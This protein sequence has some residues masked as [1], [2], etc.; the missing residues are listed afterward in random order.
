MT[1][2]AFEQVFGDIRLSA[3]VRT[4]LRDAR[5][6]NIMYFKNTN[7]FSVDI[8]AA[9]IV[10]EECIEHFKHDLRES[11][12]FVT[13][14]ILNIKY[15]MGERTPQQRIDMYWDNLLKSIKKQSFYA[16]LALK[17]SGRS[18]DEESY[19]IEL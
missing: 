7:T 6:S 16:Y 3:N 2:K 17:D 12:P 11:F 1:P 4:N 9:N 5:V 13:D 8:S 10:E 19:R 14:I 15:D 18:L